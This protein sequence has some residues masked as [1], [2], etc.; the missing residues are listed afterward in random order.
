[1]VSSST[2]NIGDILEYQVDTAIPHYD[3]KTDLESIK[4]I[5]TD[6]LS[7]GLDFI[8][9]DK[10]SIVVADFSGNNKT[11]V[12]DVDYTIEYNGKTMTINFVYSNIMA[13]NTL[14]LRYNVV[15]NKNAIVGG[16]AI[17]ILGLLLNLGMKQKLIHMVF[18]S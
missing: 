15:I 11:L 14:Q 13:Y 6:T 7:V 3:D 10:L 5:I 8:N 18:K 1:M 2:N 9:Q 17:L 16:G 4:Y 12:K